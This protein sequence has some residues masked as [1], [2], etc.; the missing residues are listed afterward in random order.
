MCQQ[1]AEADP[2]QTER[3]VDAMHS[4]ASLVH[5]IWSSNQQGQPSNG[6]NFDYQ[7]VR[8]E[9]VGIAPSNAAYIFLIFHQ[10]ILSLEWLFDN[11]PRGAYC[12]CEVFRI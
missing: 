5:E 11:F 3:I 9:E 4:F 1:Y 8:W 6:F 7:F 10:L 12:F 2:S